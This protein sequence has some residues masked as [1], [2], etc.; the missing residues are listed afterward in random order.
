VT[1]PDAVVHSDSGTPHVCAAAVTSIARA[2]APTWRIGIQLTGVAVLPPAPC[3]W[4]FVVSSDACSTRTFAQSTSS[5]SAMIIGSIVFTPC[6]I[7]GFLA[8]IVTMPSGVIR[9]NAFGTNSGAL[10]ASVAA[11][12]SA[13]STNWR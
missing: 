1:T 2:A 9:M 13:L 6:P 5:S 8:M 3:A 7:S 4:Y 11:K 12:A 10:G